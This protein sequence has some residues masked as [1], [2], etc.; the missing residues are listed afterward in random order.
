MLIDYTRDLNNNIIEYACKIKKN[1]KK[2]KM[3]TEVSKKLY[4]PVRTAEIVTVNTHPIGTL[5]KKDVFER[6]K[7]LLEP[8]KPNEIIM[9]FDAFFNFIKTW[10]IKNEN[11]ITTENIELG[12]KKFEEDIFCDESRVKE[13]IVKFTDLTLALLNIVPKGL[14]PGE[15]AAVF[16]FGQKQPVQPYLAHFDVLERLEQIKSLFDKRSVKTGSSLSEDKIS[17]YKRPMIMCLVAHKMLDQ[18]KSGA[19]K[20]GA[21][22]LMMHETMA[23]KWINLRNYFKMSINDILTREFQK[24]GEYGDAKYIR[25]CIKNKKIKQW[26]LTET[27]LLY[28]ISSPHITM[29]TPSFGSPFDNSLAAKEKALKKK[30]GNEY[31][32]MLQRV[33]DTMDYD[34]FMKAYN[35]SD[36]I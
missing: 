24:S 10:S 22:K 32:K 1:K 33:S 27:P 16:Q 18:Q 9:I 23:M 19:I 2:S 34:A 26:E 17:F 4:A 35:H 8:L 14:G 21:Q 15:I 5:I 3:D 7:F 30:Y 20:F 29:T 6:C 13:N 11:G 36:D 28:N 12:I 31:E 25:F